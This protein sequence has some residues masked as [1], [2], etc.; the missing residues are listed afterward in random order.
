MRRR[1]AIGLALGLIAGTAYY[2]TGGRVLHLSLDATPADPADLGIRDATALPLVVPD[3]SLQVWNVPAAPGKPTIFYLQGVAGNLA[4]RAGRFR[5][6]TERGY[7]LIAPGYRGSSG[8]T[9][10]PARDALLDDAAA[11]YRLVDPARTII[12][13]ESLGSSVALEMLGTKG[14]NQPAALILEAPAQSWTDLARRRTGIF[15]WLPG[16]LGHGWDARAAAPKVTAPVLILHGTEDRLV[17]LD[18]SQGIYGALGSDEKMLYRVSG[19]GHLNIW[20]AET[21]QIIFDFVDAYTLA[22]R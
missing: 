11:L 2:I 6:F 5:R 10:D 9:G 14:V 17:P 18:Q 15:G 21:R 7:G 8:S 1:L 12:Y 16:W 19:A 4:D 13:G 3:A 20:R 22:V